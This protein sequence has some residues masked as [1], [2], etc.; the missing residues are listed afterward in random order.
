MDLTPLLTFLQFGQV[1]ADPSP[2]ELIG[3]ELDLCKATTSIKV[4]FLINPGRNEDN[5]ANKTEWLGV[6]GSLSFGLNMIGT[7]G[8]ELR[9]ASISLTMVSGVSSVKI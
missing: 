5:T 7:R 8:W 6:S 9:I 1:F 4:L 3:Y 2:P